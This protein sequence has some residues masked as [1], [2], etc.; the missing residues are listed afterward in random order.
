MK[1]DVGRAIQEL[2]FDQETVIVPGLGGFTSAPSP[3]TVDYVQGVVTPPSKKIEFNPNLV[4]N[5][6]VLVHHIQKRETV[7]FQ[8]AGEAVDRF[9]DE[10][11]QALERR[12]I[13]EIPQVGR[14]YKDYEHKVRFLPEGNNFNADAFGLP[15]VQFSPLAKERHKEAPAPSVKIAVSPAP[16]V[17][18]EKP[19]VTAPPP[20]N[21]EPEATAPVA[22]IATGSTNWLQ[23]FLP[24]LVLFSA[25]L[26]AASVYL[27]FRGGGK[28]TN[29]PSDK[30]RINVKP[31]VEEE[32]AA[33]GNETTTSPGTATLP[34]TA[35]S[36]K[37]N[38]PAAPAPEKSIPDNVDTESDT[39]EPGKKT[40]FMVVHSF[41][42][43]GNATK[44]ARKLSEAGY[45]PE[46]KRVGN[47]YR[48]GVVFPYSNQQE[49]EAMRKELARKFKAGPK[50]E[51]ELAEQEQ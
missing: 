4:I 20:A 21:K 35:P 10:V 50:T 12:E 26:L 29:L 16:P 32:T 36:G 22:A 9:V 39:Y 2:L 34:P 47:L 37:E 23:K 41:G 45:S 38:T 44:F 24:W 49:V 6:G 7:T 28:D 3:A 42:V 19:A 31:K 18:K 25:V 30:E 1:I 5:D 43:K 14:L 46:T 8:E 11:K 33:S 17:E 51:K 40:L 13:I 15:V 48:V 27:I